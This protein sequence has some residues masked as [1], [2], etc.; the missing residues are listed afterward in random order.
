MED[1]DRQ[2][3]AVARQVVFQRGVVGAAF[4]G[5]QIGVAERDAAVVIDDLGVAQL[6]GVRP[7]HGLGVGQAQLH[8]V[9]QVVGQRRRRQEVVIVAR[10]RNAGEVAEVGARALAAHAVDLGV[11]LLPAA[12]EDQAVALAAV[13]GQAVDRRHVLGHHPVRADGV[14]VG[15][16]LVDGEAVAVGRKEAVEGVKVDDQRVERA[17]QRR[18]GGARFK[19]VER[20]RRRAGIGAVDGLGAVVVALGLAQLDPG[21]EAPARAVGLAVIGV[22]GLELADHV[23]GVVDV[24]VVALEGVL[25]GIGEA[26]VDVGG[27]GDA[28][29]DRDVKGRRGARQVELQLARVLQEGGFRVGGAAGQAVQFGGAP[30]E[31]A[32]DDGQGLLQREVVEAHEAAVHAA[33]QLVRQAQFVVVL[34]IVRAGQMDV[35]GV[36]GLVLQLHRGAVAVDRVGIALIQ[37]LGVGRRRGRGRI[38]HGLVGAEA[39]LVAALLAVVGAEQ[40]AELVLVAEGLR[41]GA[42]EAE[43]HA[44]VAA[45]IIALA[46]HGGRVGAADEGVGHGVEAVVIEG[47]TGAQVHRAADGVAVDVGRARLDDL[48]AADGGRGDGLHVQLAVAALG[49]GHGGAVEAAQGV[50]GVQPAHRDVAALVLV[51]HGLDAGHPAQAVGDVVVGLLADVVA[52]QELGDA[53]VFPLGRDRALVLGAVADDDDV[54]DL[55]RLLSC[56]RGVLSGRRSGCRAHGEGQDADGGGERSGASRRLEQ[57]HGGIPERND[58]AAHRM[59]E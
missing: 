29:P 8:I 14:D 16:G 42:V 44:V 15:A 49:R 19:G 3:A 41:H 2:H 43:I 57:R 45:A 17:A 23:V 6:A 10:L 34:L 58:G 48:Q 35:Q 27:V 1:A 20:Q 24:G 59:P 54:L 5:L 38:R 22:V 30:V 40:D 55:G 11:R 21:L 28:V 52:V 33:A 53:R 56:G 51:E 39:L 47:R 32:L 12:A 4:A 37:Q 9:G 50:A 13:L 31:A 25:G 46:G 18:V 36:A 7:A 26:R